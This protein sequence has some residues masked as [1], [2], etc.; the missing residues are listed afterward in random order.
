MPAGKDH[1]CLKGMERHGDA[2]CTL[3]A[4]SPSASLARCVHQDCI[5]QFVSLAIARACDFSECKP[6]KASL[7]QGCAPEPGCFICTGLN[8]TANGK[9]DVGH[10]EEKVI[11]PSWGGSAAE[12]LAYPSRI[13]RSYCMV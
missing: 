7:Y 10:R 1:L 3:H 6:Q 9:A 2:C 11:L 12:H 8:G 5:S 13:P 4:M